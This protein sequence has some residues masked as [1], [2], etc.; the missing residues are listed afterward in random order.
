[1]GDWV[2]VGQL[3]V[4]CLKDH[5]SQQRFID[6]GWKYEVEHYWKKHIAPTFEI[7]SCNTVGPKFVR[8]WHKTLSA[9][10]TTANRCLEVLARVFSFGEEEELIPLGTNPCRYVKGGREK[11]RTRY[12]SPE[13]IAKLGEAMRKLTGEYPAQTAFCTTLA[14]TGA[15]PRSLERVRRDQL[16]VHGDTG[17]LTFSG[18][19]TEKTGEDEVII[20]P[21]EALRLLVALPV[22]ED[23]L[24]F[25]PVV[26]RR[27]WERVR[28]MAG[29]ETL[30]LRDIR[31]TWATVGLSDG[32][33][34]DWIGK[35]LNHR[36]SQTTDRY[37]KL[38]Q[39][40]KIGASK[41]IALRM[42]ALLGGAA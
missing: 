24:L 25:G 17:I 39:L 2:K 6:S 14:L 38:M 1:M 3:Y 15:R 13:E 31:R 4:R 29:C 42:S 22:R 8:E 28:E 32:V 19:S 41:R 12:A 30:W 5:W 34:K 9:T 40:Q 21:P 7:I 26:Y 20:V 11:Q 37:A 27:Y 36:S 16:V 35:L 33:D 18:K 23:G 10:P